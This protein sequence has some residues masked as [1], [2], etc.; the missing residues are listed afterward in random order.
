MEVSNYMYV[1]TQY[2]QIVVRVME[3]NRLRGRKGSFEMRER[4]HINFSMVAGEGLASNDIRAE[5]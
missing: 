2:Y 1:N 4:C 3:K 5:E